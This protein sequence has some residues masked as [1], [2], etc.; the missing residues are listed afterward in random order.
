MISKHLGVWLGGGASR[1]WNRILFVAGWI[2]CVS[3]AAVSQ[4]AM[5]DSFESYR[6]IL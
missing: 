6:G 1:R 4:G 2:L 3:A 5:I